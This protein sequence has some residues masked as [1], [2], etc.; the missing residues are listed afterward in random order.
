MLRGGG[1]TGLEGLHLL[2]L[3]VK[4]GTHPTV[5]L[6]VKSTALSSEGGEGCDALH[7]SVV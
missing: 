3:G 1:R 5:L 2:R 4:E 7:G 6:C